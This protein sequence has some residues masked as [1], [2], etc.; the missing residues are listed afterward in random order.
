MTWKQYILALANSPLPKSLF[1]KETTPPLQ[2]RNISDYEDAVLRGF[3]G[4]EK[5]YK[6]YKWDSEVEEHFLPEPSKNNITNKKKHVP[7]DDIFATDLASKVLSEGILTVEWELE[8]RLIDKLSSLVDNS[9]NNVDSKIE[10]LEFSLNAE[11]ELSNKRLNATNEKLDK[12]VVQI[13]EKIDV[14]KDV[15]AEDISTKV[16]T[17]NTDLT[18]IHNETKNELKNKSDKGHKHRVEDIEWLGK[19][20]KTL[21][22]SLDEKATFEEVKSAIDNMYTKDETYNKA[23]IN[24][25]IDSIKPSSTIIKTWWI[26]SSSNLNEVSSASTTVPNSLY[27]MTSGVP[28]EFRS[29]DAN[30]ILYID[31][32]TENV[33][34][35]T[36]TPTLAKLQIKSST[37]SAVV[38]SE[39]ITNVA[40]RDFSSDT[41]N[42]TWTNWTIGSW[43]ITHTAWANT[44]T[45]NNAALSVAP[46]SWL[47][48]RVAF[49]VN[50]TVAGSLVCLMGSG[51]SSWPSFGR[52]VGSVTYTTNQIA[53]GTNA[54]KFI[55]D[56]TWTGT[57]DNVSIKIITPIPNVIVGTNSSWSPRFTGRLTS[58]LYSTAYGNN[59]LNIATGDYNTAFGYMAGHWVTTGT[60]SI[61]FWDFAGQ[62]ITTSTY[63]TAIGSNCMNFALTW[64]R[65]TAIGSNSLNVNNWW[66]DVMAIGDG[67]FQANVT[68]SYGVAIGSSAWLANTTWSY[69][70]FIGGNSW[71]NNTTWSYNTT[72]GY[73]AQC[74]SATANGQ[75]SIQNIIF[76]TGNTWTITTVSSWSIGI[77][78]NAPYRRFHVEMNWSGTNAVEYATRFTNTTSGT[79]TTGYWIWLE[80]EL[81]NAS[82]TN[83]IACTS[84]ISY[85]D[86]TNATE[87]AQYII[88]LI[89]AGTLTTAMTISSLWAVTIT[90][91]F[92]SAWT[93]QCWSGNAYRIGSRSVILS[94]SDGTIY[95]TNNAINDFNRLQFW[96]TTSSF[97]SLKRSWTWLVARLADDSADTDITA[98]KVIS[99]AVVRLKWYVVSGLPEWVIWDT[100]YV[101]DAT[102]PKWWTDVSWWW[103]VVVPVFYNGDKR[104]VA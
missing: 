44:L 92:T 1:D 14:V 50:T 9:I 11:K 37:T 97:P 48:Y 3:K 39:Q 101:T 81:E 71:R 74:P 84:E 31:E 64:T 51:G 27:Q 45:L 2:P 96:G 33:W 21:S 52:T 4:T 68:W 85:T 41:G 87:D 26:W 40:D 12:K 55:P 38:G 16:D 77:G 59:S 30:P 13:T 10:S 49:T 25:K 17:L 93:I 76:W 89:R 18:N 70:N 75:L 6:S 69:N 100:C 28:V 29:S 72:L 83:R 54:L 99:T 42:W 63:V 32:A 8:T 103:S 34:F 47:L 57:I 43:V 91:S 67:S 79:V 102:E 56:A 5:Y 20:L 36:N 60:S 46:V 61:F 82:G 73:Y 78:T 19:E 86:A 94:A 58:W 7:E 65:C 22:V 66:T 24:D 53:T 90:D 23:E 88:K 35:G 98:A 80:F 95:L 15:I 62:Y 104:I